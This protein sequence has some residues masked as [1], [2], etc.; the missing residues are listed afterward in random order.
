[1]GTY[2]FTDKQ[3]ETLVGSLEEIGEALIWGP[4]RRFPDYRGYGQGRLT[5]NAEPWLGAYNYP[6]VASTLEEFDAFD[7]AEDD[8]RPFTLAEWVTW[9]AHV[10]DRPEGHTSAALHLV[11]A[12]GCVVEDEQSW[13]E[14]YAYLGKVADEITDEQRSTM[15]DVVRLLKRRWPGGSF[16][17]ELTEAMRAALG[18]V[19]G[20]ATPEEMGQ[21]WAA[22]SA[23]YDA[24]QQRITG[25]IVAM[26]L[27]DASEYQVAVLLGIS[28]QTVRKALGK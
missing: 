22:A 24:A 2:S 21:E 8:P 19:L 4:T 27:A 1:M 18:I 12:W 3:G 14:L 9:A 10:E 25:V 15:S 28:R 23:A 26:S 20:D 11:H 17:E 16:T 6:V 13:S 5:D 7:R